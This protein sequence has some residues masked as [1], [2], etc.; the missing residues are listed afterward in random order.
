[1]F[2]EVG[3]DEPMGAKLRIPVAT[4]FAEQADHILDVGICGPVGAK[5][6]IPLAM[7]FAEQAVR[8]SPIGQ[9]RLALPL[10]SH[11]L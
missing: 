6:R 1:M 3:V 2:F 7:S 9:S 10:P 5:L 4:S 8:S 11:P